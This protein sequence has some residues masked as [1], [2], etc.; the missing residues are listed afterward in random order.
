MNMGKA[1]TYF[2]QV[3]LTVAKRIAQ[4]ET[5]VSVTG[6]V[7][8]AICGLRVELEQCKVNEDGQAVHEKCYF[9]S[10]MSPPDLRRSRF[11]T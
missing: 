8:C 10:M 1:K 6:I 4:V 2:E 11:G 3:P 7:P 9:A 5:K